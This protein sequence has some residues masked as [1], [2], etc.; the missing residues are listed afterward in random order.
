MHRQ[1]SLSRDPS[2]LATH[3]LFSDLSSNDFTGE[4]STGSS[5]IS[6]AFYL[7]SAMMSK[8]SRE[9]PRGGGTNVPLRRRSNARNWYKTR[10]Q[11]GT[12]ARRRK[13][14]VRILMGKRPLNSILCLF[15]IKLNSSSE[16]RKLF[17]KLPGRK[18]R[19]HVIS[20]SSLAPVISTTKRRTHVLTK[21][22]K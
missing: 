19:A 5:S 20:L 13:A 2:Q 17:Y 11:L 9:S 14:P 12:H 1:V 6:L 3:E 4:N 8:R 16:K 15:A 18:N 10:A 22:R 21:Q 7:I